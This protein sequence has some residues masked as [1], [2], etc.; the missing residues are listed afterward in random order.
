M[1]NKIKCKNCKSRY[2]GCHSEC[3]DYTAY[4]EERDNILNIKYKKEQELSTLNSY[5]S[6]NSRRMIKR[7]GKIRCRKK[8]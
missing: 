2:I 7:K 1:K 4:R 5:I 8:Y 6:T 3:A